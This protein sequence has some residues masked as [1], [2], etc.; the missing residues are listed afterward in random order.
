MLATAR[1]QWKQ[2]EAY[3]QES[4]EIAMSSGHDW[5]RNETLN[6]IGELYLKQQHIDEA[7]AV[8]QEVLVKVKQMEMQYL[9]AYAL[10]GLARVEATRH[11]FA[12]AHRK[13]QAS[14]ALFTRLENV[15][16]K[17]VADWLEHMR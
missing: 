9:E 13:G 7:E 12:E 11:N 3:L 1:K 16:A 2:A 17:Q 5:L 10:Y 15:M 4:L 14:H 6:E 8:F